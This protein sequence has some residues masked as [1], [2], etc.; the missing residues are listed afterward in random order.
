ME[1]SEA[2]DDSA[3]S[4]RRNQEEHKMQHSTPIVG[5][6]VPATSA[7]F[8]KSTATQR[9]AAANKI[10][11]RNERECI[12]VE[13][14]QTDRIARTNDKEIDEWYAEQDDEYE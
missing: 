6:S 2:Q 7:V 10:T 4:A 11:A 12:G 14:Y 9:T 13:K 8:A 5:S 3:T 1:A